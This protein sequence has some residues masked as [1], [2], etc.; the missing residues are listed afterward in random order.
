[1]VP[2]AFA[3]SVGPESK[4]NWQKVFQ[5]V[6]SVVKFDIPERPIIID[7]EKGIEKAFGR[8][9]I[10]TKMFLDPLHVQKNMLKVLGAERSIAVSLY[11]RALH[12]P[13]RVQKDEII[14]QHGPNQKKYLS[15][16][17]KSVLY[18]SYS[19]L[20]DAITTSQGHESRMAAS[21]KTDIR[22]VGPQRMLQRVVTLQRESFQRRKHVVLSYSKHVTPRIKVHLAELIMTSLIYSPSVQFKDH[23][24][25]EA[26][27]KSAHNASVF[28]RVVFSPIQRSPCL[29]RV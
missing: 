19:N 24:K 23:N 17:D 27:V 9:F 10:H 2:T 12:A 22:R 13:L 7:Q 8:V 20:R 21:L 18:R 6:S 1:M 15:K 3:H 5:A 29:L 14:Q 25:M 26:T 28:R 4:E 11:K 16:F